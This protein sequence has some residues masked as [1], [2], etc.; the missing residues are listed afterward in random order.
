MMP[1]SKEVSPIDSTRF[2][3]WTPEEGRE[4]EIGPDRRRVLL[5]PIPLPVRREDMADGGPGGD[6]IG[7]GA[8]DYLREF[9]DCPFNAEYAGLLRDA[10]P[11]Y[12]ADLGAHAAMLEHKEVDTP[13][14]RRLLTCLK[15]LA[16]LDPDNFALLQRIGMTSYDLGMSFS[17]L[18]SVRRQLLEAMG[19]LQRALGLRPDDPACLNLLGQ[20]D[21]LL[22]DYPTAARRWRQAAAGVTDLRVR[23]ALLERAERISAGAVP[24]HPL[25]DDLEAIGSALQLYGSGA[26]REAGLILERLEEEGTVPAEFPSAEFHFLLGMCR[27]RLGDP[28]GAFAS[29]DKALQ[30]DPEYAPARSAMNRIL[31]EGSLENDAHQRR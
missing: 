8:Y 1:K 29:F 30:I 27:G 15:I 4:V 6:A 10:F 31:D 3:L 20:I 18:V 2:V 12:V 13:Y 23:S 14:L 17:E 16:L 5:P 28:G 22:G 26:I 11:H 21:F 9:P 24:D 19:Y 7:R 25:L